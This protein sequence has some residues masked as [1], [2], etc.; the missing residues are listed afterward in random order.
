MIVD[1]TNLYIKNHHTCPCRQTKHVR[2]STTNAVN[3]V[4]KN[5]MEVK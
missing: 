4:I 5:H 3:E 2:W 1:Y